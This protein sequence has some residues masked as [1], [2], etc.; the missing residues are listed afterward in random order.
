MAFTG[1]VELLALG[2]AQASKETVHRSISRWYY[3]SWLRSEWCAEEDI[4]PTPGGV[5]CMKLRIRMNT[6]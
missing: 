2:L 5:G 4:D 3:D 6:T 1:E